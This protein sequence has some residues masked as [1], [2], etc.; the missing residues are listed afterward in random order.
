MKKPRELTLSTH[1]KRFVFDKARTAIYNLSNGGLMV[2]GIPNQSQDTDFDYTVI[3]SRTDNKPL[4]NQQA[5]WAETT[6]K[7][8]DYALR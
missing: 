5:E 3:L 8:I 2:G 4:T 1:V 7:A 6:L